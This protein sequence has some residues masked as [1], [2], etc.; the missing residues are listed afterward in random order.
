MESSKRPTTFVNLGEERPATFDTLGDEIMIQI[1]RYVP[2]G[3][4]CM[5]QLNL[6]AKR[7]E[8]SEFQALLSCMKFKSL[9]ELKRHADVSLPRLF[10]NIHPVLACSTACALP[11]SVI[12]TPHA[13]T[14][15]ISHLF[16][17]LPPGSGA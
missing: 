13:I 15:G 5:S 10:H 7:L 16:A 8:L 14:R 11:L 6:D 17:H 9:E 12:S 1:A 3:V 2:L 4:S